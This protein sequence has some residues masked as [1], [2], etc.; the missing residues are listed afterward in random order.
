MTWTEHVMWMEMLWAN[1]NLI[2]L[3]S[4]TAA[5]TTAPQAFVIGSNYIIYV[6]LLSGLR[7]S[8]HPH[9]LAHICHK[10]IIDIA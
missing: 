9:L 7:K 8:T 3:C 4:S 1:L 5:E 6:L 10:Y 2:H